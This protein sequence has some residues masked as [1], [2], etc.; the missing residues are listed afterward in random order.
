MNEC[1][2][3]FRGLKR[4]VFLCGF[5]GLMTACTTPARQQSAGDIA[6]FEKA[7]RLSEER[8]RR[9]ATV[10]QPGTY[11]RSMWPDGEVRCVKAQDWTSG[12]FP[13][14]L[15]YMYELSGDSYFKGKAIMFTQGLDS[16]QYATNTHDLG[17]IINNSFGNGFRLTQDSSWQHVLLNSARSLSSRYSTTVGGIKSWDNEIRSVKNDAFNFP[18]IIDNMMNLELL[19]KA[20][21]ATGDSSFYHIATSHADLTIRNHF[22]DDGSSYHVIDYDSLTGIV[23]R[24][25]THQGFSDESAWARGQAWGLYGYVMMYKETAQEK[26][27]IH[28]KKIAHFIMHHPRLPEDKVPYW[29]FDAPNIPHVLRDASAAAVM[30]SAML[31]LSTVSKENAQY[32]QFGEA[33]LQNL[34]DK[35]VTENNADE[36]FIVHHAVGNFRNF[37]EVN[38]PLNYA[39]YY[40]LES[41]S[42]YKRLKGHL[43]L[44][45]QAALKSNSISYEASLSNK[46]IASQ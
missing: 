15:W 32:F 46:I 16:I 2:S 37:S 40:F 19:L 20:F 28:A 45:S 35:Y 36:I 39:D 25:L 21:H 43:G 14:S 11:P 22:R 10:M 29:D 18:I 41:L 38:T 31:D 3:A 27:L 24:R 6:W 1:P 17:F 4:L 7:V 34:T 5:F 12:F 26:Y 42:K 13:G 23:K 8:M 9:A 44:E 30:A 33:I